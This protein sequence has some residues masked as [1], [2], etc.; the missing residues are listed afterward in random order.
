MSSQFEAQRCSHTLVFKNN[1]AHPI[2]FATEG[3]TCWK[4]VEF[5]YTSASVWL[6]SSRVVR[7]QWSVQDVTEKYLK[8]NAFGETLL[9]DVMRRTIDANAKNVCIKEICRWRTFTFQSVSD[10]GW[11]AEGSFS[12]NECRIHLGAMQ[13][14]TH[15]FQRHHG[16][17]ASLRDFYNIC[18]FVWHTEENSNMSLSGARLVVLIDSSRDLDEPSSRVHRL[19]NDWWIDLFLCTSLVSCL[20]PW[21][22]STTSKMS[23]AGKKTGRPHVDYRLRTHRSCHQEGWYSVSS[24][25]S[26]NDLCCMSSDSLPDVLSKTFLLLHTPRLVSR[27]RVQNIPLWEGQIRGSCWDAGPVLHQKN[28]DPALT[29]HVCKRR[30]WWKYEKLDRLLADVNDDFRHVLIIFTS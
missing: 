18:E 29:I 15:K 6:Y 7:R 9:S 20:L 2:R 19:A 14:W 1:N 10:D 23:N 3:R 28:V 30:T 8:R 24:S 16:T 26:G 11:Y 22:A 13:R 25:A 17:I 27:R 5:K 12:R 21:T 4:H